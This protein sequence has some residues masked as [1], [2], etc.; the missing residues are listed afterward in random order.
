MTLQE[1]CH[2]YQNDRNQYFPDTGILKLALR[3][4]DQLIRRLRKQG[5]NEGLI[6][7]L[8]T[9]RKAVLAEIDQPLATVEVT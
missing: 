9:G 8:T 3:Q 4:R 5:G 1:L 2:Q 6:Q 7:V